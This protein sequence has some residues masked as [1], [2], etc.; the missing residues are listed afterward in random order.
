[1]AQNLHLSVKQVAE[2]FGVSVA[3]IWRWSRDGVIPAPIRI[4]TGCTR[5]R[6]ADLEE[7]EAGR[8]GGA[9]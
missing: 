8:F 9:A 7:W 2:R 5:W 6:A 1:M 3:T 4:S